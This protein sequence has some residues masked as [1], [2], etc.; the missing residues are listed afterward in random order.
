MSFKAFLILKNEDPKSNNLAF[1]TEVEAAAYGHAK[2]NAWTT[3]IG[4]EVRASDDPA[5]YVWNGRFAIPLTDHPRWV[6]P[7]GHAAPADLTGELPEML[8]IHDDRPAAEQLDAHYQ[9]GG[10]FRPDQ[11]QYQL[12]T[13]G[14]L[15]YPGDEPLPE[16]A[17][18]QLRRESIRLFPYGLVAV[19]Q[20]D[21]SFAVGRMD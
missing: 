10:G 7:T 18:A 19:V 9:H 12:G 17:R 2:L 3:P 16:Q 21:G 1:E 8:N 11:G 15:L 14:E 4:Y 13:H 6:Q 20:Q 5:N